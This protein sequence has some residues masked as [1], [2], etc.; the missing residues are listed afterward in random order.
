MHRSDSLFAA[1][2]WLNQR[3]GNNMHWCRKEF[4]AWFDKKWVKT[5]I[6]NKSNARKI[7]HKQSKHNELSNHISV[8]HVIHK[9]YFKS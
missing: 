1:K 4:Y 5:E 8:S 6:E 2:E 7:S 9:S 3:E